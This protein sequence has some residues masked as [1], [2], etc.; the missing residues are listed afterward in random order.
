MSADERTDTAEKISARY[1]YSRNG[2]G[3]SYTFLEF[4]STGCSACRQMEAVMKTVR[5]RY[6]G[7]VNVVFI[8]AAGIGNQDL[9]DYYG[10][11]TQ[12]ILDR[13]GQERY[14]LNGVI[15]AE[16]LAVHFE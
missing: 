4:G 2:S 10:I 7:R 3:F 5:E 13:N 15:T 16:E 8:D 14:R 12:I 1:D 9:M 11:V 6:P